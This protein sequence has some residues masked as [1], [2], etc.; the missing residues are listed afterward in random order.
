MAERKQKSH[1]TELLDDVEKAHKSDI[2]LYVSGHLNHNKLFKPHKS[3]K[4]NYW[5]SAK[6]PTLLS[7][8]EDALGGPHEMLEKVSSSKDAPPVPIRAKSASPL[9]YQS[10]VHPASFRAPV[11][12]SLNTAAFKQQKKEAPE[13]PEE[14]ASTF[15]KQLIREELD[16]PEMRLLKYRRLKSSRLCVTKEFKDEYLFLP[17]Y[18]AGVTKKDQYNKFMQVQ[19]E[20]VAKQDLLENDFIGSKSTE[21]HEKKLAQVSQWVQRNDNVCA[22]TCEKSQIS[23][24]LS[25][26]FY[27]YAGFSP[28]G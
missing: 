10:P 8:K 3:A 12:M 11:S 27:F 21:R 17:S 25:Q 18:L 14:E 22:L 6:K 1:L 13:K 2:R 16:I 28:D 26:W 24:T 5:V 19:K 7:A 23:H 20:Y 9:G 4:Y 15:P